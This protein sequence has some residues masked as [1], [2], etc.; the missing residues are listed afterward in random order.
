MRA[1]VG[2]LSVVAVIALLAGSSGVLAQGRGAG[3]MTIDEVVA[4]ALADNPDLLAVRAEVEAAGGRL[5]QAGLRPNP[6]LELGGQKAIGPD[7][8]LSVGLTLPLDLNGRVDG[9][10]GVAQREVEMKRALVAERERRLAAEVR[11][12]AGE[13]LA[14][15]RN[16]EVTDELLRINRDGLRLVGDRVREGAAPQL[17]EN[18]LLVEV[19]RLDASG[20]MLASR[21]TVLTLQLR[22]L[23]GMEPDAPLTLRG[24][25]AGAAPAVGRAEAM[26]QA[27]AGRPDL[28]VARADAAIARAKVRKEEAEG[29]WDASVSVGYQRQ[30]FGFSGLRGVASNGSLQPIQDI[31][32]Y[33]GAGVTVTLPVRN[34][35]QGNV[36][37]AVAETRAAERRQEFMALVIRQEVEAAF[38]QL[39]AARRALGLYE[40]GVRDV[41]QRNLEVVRRTWELGRGTL[42]DVIAE[43][44]RLIEVENGYTDALKQVFDATVEI[45]RAVGLTMSA[46]RG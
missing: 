15:R 28:E 6:M 7:S 42:L 26:T 9:R 36:A 21:E 13:L 17:E 14:A 1:L 38:T 4:R 35:N 44:R 18:L 10:V 31:F 30:D 23:A 8:N 45:D 43:Q 34:R 24:E 19:N 32:H 12:K 25:L 5:R 40:R 37:A 11:L 2:R 22:A 3:V 16:V 41:A 29:R 27:L 20:Q 39:E 33:F 46:P